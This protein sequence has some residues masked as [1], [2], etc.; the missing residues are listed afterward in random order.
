MKKIK[1]LFFTL[2]ISL[3]LLGGSAVL[4]PQLAGVET[5]EAAAVSIN[6]STL[7][8][9]P[10][11]KYRLTVTGTSQKVRWRSSKPKVASVGSRGIVTAKA[12]GRAKI[13]AVV[14]GRKYS[15]VVTVIKDTEDEFFVSSTNVTV[16][17]KASVILTSENYG[18]VNCQVDDPDIVSYKWGDWEGHTIEIF[19]TGK[20]IG[21][22]KIRIS[23][24][25]LDEVLVINVNVIDYYNVFKVSSTDVTINETGSVTVTSINNGT[26]YLKNNDPDIISC[27]WSHDWEGDTTKI[28]ITAKRSGKATITITNDKNDKKLVVHVTVVRSGGSGK[29]EL[30]DYIL[31]YGSYNSDGNKF[32]R[33]DHNLVGSSNSFAIVYSASEDS[34]SFIAGTEGYDT[35]DFDYEYESTVEMIV[36]NR[37]VSSVTADYLFRFTDKNA[38]FEAVATINVATFNEDSILNIRIIDSPGIPS[39]AIETCKKLANK[40]IQLAMLGWEMLLTGEADMSLQDLGFVSYNP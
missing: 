35:E 23:N 12:P 24:S 13:V 38:A 33:M 1:K 36:P 37:D 5:V 22:T 2:M 32:I 26:L 16:D 14:G 20:S 21:K 34:F 6:P 9:H 4:F 15:C 8:L 3:L 18:R 29:D 40:E 19:L 30:K 17:K 11:E 28:Y 7:T 31:K 10:G 25:W 27:D 39:N